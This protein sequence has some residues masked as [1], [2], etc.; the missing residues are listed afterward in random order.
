MG[1]GETHAGRQP[2]S[3]AC[4]TD[5]ATLEAVEL[6]KVFRAHRAVDGVSVRVEPGTLQRLTVHVDPDDDPARQTME[7]MEPDSQM[8]DG[9][10]PNPY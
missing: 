3:A 8:D 1:S 2:N 4:E 6:L 7:S 9:T 10:F 5:G